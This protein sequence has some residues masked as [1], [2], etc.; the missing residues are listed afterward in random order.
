MY[1]SVLNMW[2]IRVLFEN[3]YSQASDEV[4]VSAP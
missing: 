3:L 1:N 2:D 4:A